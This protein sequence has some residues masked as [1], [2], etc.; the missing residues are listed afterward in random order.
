MAERKLTSAQ[1]RMLARMREKQDEGK[2]LGF[3]QQWGW[4]PGPS[5]WPAP[6]IRVDTLQALIRRG[7]V[8]QDPGLGQQPVLYHVARCHDC[9]LPYDDPGFADLVVAHDV[10]AKIS[11][12]GCEGGLL[13]PTCMVRACV[14]QGIETEA[15][16]RS[17]PFFAEQ[18]VESKTYRGCV[19]RTNKKTI[20]KITDTQKK[21]LGMLS[22]QWQHSQE[23]GKRYKEE[24]RMEPV[25]VLFSL[26]LMTERGYIQNQKGTKLFRLIPGE[27]DDNR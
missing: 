7:V 11:P 6:G 4:Y 8:T 21:L 17:G 26:R 2:S 19:N 1:M 16:F 9:G 23:I 27:L 25:R 5:V 24:T 15:V 12:T 20:P 13:C 10:W 14:A 18:L 22:D 3:H